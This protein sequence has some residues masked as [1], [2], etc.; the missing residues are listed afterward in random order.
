MTTYLQDTNDEKI[1]ELA[2]DLY[3]LYTNLDIVNYIHNGKVL[4]FK[5]QTLISRPIP[6]IYSNVEKKPSIQTILTNSIKLSLNMSTH[7]KNTN[8]LKIYRESCERFKMSLSLLMRKKQQGIQVNEIDIETK[9]KEIKMLE[10]KINEIATIAT[11]KPEIN[12]K[13]LTNAVTIYNVMLRNDRVPK[14]LFIKFSKK[15]GYYFNY[16]ERFVDDYDK[17]NTFNGLSVKQKQGSY[18]P[19]A[20][21]S[22][23]IDKPKQTNIHDSESESEETQLQTIINNKINKTKNNNDKIPNYDYYVN[24]NIG[25]WATKSKIIFNSKDNNDHKDHKH[26]DNNDHKHEDTHKSK[27]KQSELKLINEWEVNDDF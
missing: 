19:P 9:I 1:I 23:N 24:K 2:N 26:E 6:G 11:F 22:E 17:S 18:I 3:E 25:V 8:E 12:K 4:P 21:R 16:T 7:T 10:Q 14:I 20:F 5:Y 27:D 15:I 13:I